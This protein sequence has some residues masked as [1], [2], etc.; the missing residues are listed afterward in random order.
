MKL[1]RDSCRIARTLLSAAELEVMRGTPEYVRWRSPA[2]RVC[3][4]HRARGS[5]DL[6]HGKEP[7]KIVV[8]AHRN[9]RA[10]LTCGDLIIEYW[11]P[12]TGGYIREI[13]KK[14]PGMY[15]PQVYADLSHRRDTLYCAQGIRLADIIRQIV[16][17]PAVR[18]MIIKRAKKCART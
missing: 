1:I 7:M 10:T 17:R 15:G 3:P 5:E 18:E 12:L 13:T 6:S 2:F 11:R 14:Q 4:A 9:H 8:T 16:R